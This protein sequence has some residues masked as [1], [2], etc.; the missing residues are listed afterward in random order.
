M[1]IRYREKKHN[2]PKLRSASD[3]RPGNGW[4]H[5][6]GPVWEHISGARIHTMGTVR[7]PDGKTIC[8][9]NK[10]PE[11]LEGIMFITVN[12]CNRKRGLMA[13]AN[14]LTKRVGLL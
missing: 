13:W 8:S 9:L 6:G 2:D 11:C 10:Y 3:V 12:G 14:A 4:Q 7:M 5:I 1:K